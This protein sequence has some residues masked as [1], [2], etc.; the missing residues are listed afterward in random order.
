MLSQIDSILII[1]TESDSLERSDIIGTGG[2]LPPEQRETLDWMTLGRVLG[3]RVIVIAPEKFTQINIEEQNIKWL[4]L[5]GNPDNLDEVELNQILHVVN[6]KPILLITPVGKMGG[7]FEK[8]AG[9]CLGNEIG[10]GNV[11][12][13]N[14]TGKKITWDCRNIIQLPS[15]KWESGYKSIVSL[16]NKE[17]VATKRIGLGK[18]VVLSFQPSFARDMEGYFTTLIKH[19]L[20]MECLAP[21]AWFNFENTLILRMDDPGSLEPVY[22]ELYQNTKLNEQDWETIGVVLKKKHARISLGYVPGFVDDGDVERGILKIDGQ[23]CSRR[24]GTVYQSHLV[25]YETI[26][27]NSNHRIYD[28]QAE[29]RGIQKLRMEELAEVELHGYTHLHPDRITW[30]NATDRYLNTSWYREFGTEQVEYIKKNPSMIH[31]FDEGIKAFSNSWNVFPTTLICP[32]DKFTNDVLQKA[33]H[34]G[35][36][37]VSSYYLC[38]RIENKFC[39]AQHICSP[40]FN[41]PDSKWFDSCLP[42]IGYFH[43]FDITIN[44]TIW[45]SNYLDQWEKAGAKYFMD[46][47]EV[48]AILNHSISIKE[49]DDMYELSVNAI[50]DSKLIRPVRMGIFF[51]DHAE[52]LELILKID[53]ADKPMKISKKNGIG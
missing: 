11:I 7:H 22:N 1:S 42:V 3:W 30:A 43:D 23:L 2:W 15:L 40:Y 17:I 38:L 50:D 52:S 6:S 49:I 20:I 41:E 44:G 35:L 13:W 28:Y 34:A 39:W 14:G 29:Y 47:K 12:Y 5:T 25:K 36:M 48:A 45:F 53:Q 24:M 37:M 18:I 16:G 51:P 19:L 8:H 4:I 21:V 10:S 46:F 32:G 26:K 27:E 9:I 33:L 31:P